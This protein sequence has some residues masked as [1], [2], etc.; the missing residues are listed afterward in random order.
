M[1]KRISSE[2]V[3]RDW[4]KALDDLLQR[5]EEFKIMINAK[6]EEVE[7]A[8]EIIKVKDE[9]IEKMIS[10]IEKERKFNQRVSG[11]LSN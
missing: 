4:L 11:N 8:Q 1:N 5:S 6:D 3:I 10:E 7:K 2:K 9:I